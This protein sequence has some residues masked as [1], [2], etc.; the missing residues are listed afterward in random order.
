M[1]TSVNVP[2]WGPVKPLPSTYGTHNGHSTR[3]LRFGDLQPRHGQLVL[4]P[5]RLVNQQRLEGRPPPG[6]RLAADGS[7]LVVAIGGGAVAGDRLQRPHLVPQLLHLQ[8]RQQL[9]PA[10]MLARSA[11]AIPLNKNNLPCKSRG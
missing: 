2:P 10:R 9:R 5:P 7:V 1:N 3:T 6:P 11:R 4:Q 8:A